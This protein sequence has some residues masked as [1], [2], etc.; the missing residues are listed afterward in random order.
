MKQKGGAAKRDKD[1]F[2]IAGAIISSHLQTPGS[3]TGR[4]PHLPRCSYRDRAGW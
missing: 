3:S 4:S 2:G 1:N